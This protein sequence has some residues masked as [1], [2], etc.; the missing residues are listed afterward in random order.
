MDKRFIHLNSGLCAACFNIPEPFHDPP[1][2][3]FPTCVNKVTSG[4]L[5]GSSRLILSTTSITNLP[6]A[7]ETA[8]VRGAAATVPVS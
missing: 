8:V 3:V 7:L 1:S 6:S 4:C 5:A 2:Q